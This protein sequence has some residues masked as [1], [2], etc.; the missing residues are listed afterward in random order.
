MTSRPR[1]VPSL[2]AVRHVLSPAPRALLALSLLACGADDGVTPAGP[3][4]GPGGC[5]V[6][7]SMRLHPLLVGATWT[8]SISEPDVPARSKTATIEALEDVGDRKAGTIAYRQRTEK[9]DGVTVSWN[10][11]R[12]TSVVRHRERNYDLGNLEESDQFYQP[13]KLRVDESRA[14]GATWTMSYTELEVD[15]ATGIAVTIAKDEVWSVVSTSESV[16]VPAGT[17]DT[18]HLRKVTSGAAEKDYWWARGVGKVRETGE[19]T[20]VLTAYS[21]PESP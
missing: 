18:V 14:A 2:A 1:I 6:P 21:F 16:T 8:Y 5:E 4:A 17:F 9:L 7:T 13:S 11:D 20:E 10:E 12:C 3:D 15:P 19:Q